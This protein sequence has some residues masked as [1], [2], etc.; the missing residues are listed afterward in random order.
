MQRIR[1]SDDLSNPLT[2]PY[3]SYDKYE[4]IRLGLN[5]FNPSEHKGLMSRFPFL[6]DYVDTSSITGK[7]ILNLSTRENFHICT[8]GRNPLRGKSVLARCVTPASMISPT[9]RV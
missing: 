4:R 7:P 1:E 5:D 9:P 6:T 8:T 2:S 3:Y